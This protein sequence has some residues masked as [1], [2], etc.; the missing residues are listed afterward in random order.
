MATSGIE[1]RFDARDQK[2]FKRMLSGGISEAM[3]RGMQTVGNALEGHI[4]E[5]I[6]ATVNNP[7]T[8]NLSRSYSMAFTRHGGGEIGV[9]VF[10]DLEYAAIQNDG[11]TIHPRTRKNLAIPISARAKQRGNWP[12]HWGKGIL[13]FVH[14][15][16]TG[17]NLLV[18]IVKKVRGKQKMIVHYVLKPFV[19]LRG[20]NY[21]E[22]AKK[23]TDVL[24]QKALGDAFI[25]EVVR[26]GE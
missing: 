12:R 13:K 20:K 9:G 22:R 16:N 15:K 6:A 23:R 14:N 25:S 21:L 24:V 5:E 2:H 19:Q 7:G 18:E 11:G 17:K 1:V 10:S 8:R 3:I 26:D 4:K